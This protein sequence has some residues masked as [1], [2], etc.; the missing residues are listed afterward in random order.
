[1]E[2]GHADV[3]VTTNVTVEATGVDAE[4]IGL[5]NENTGVATNTQVATEDD[6]VMGIVSKLVANFD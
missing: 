2:Y 1:M 5:T 6:G 4:T 3:T